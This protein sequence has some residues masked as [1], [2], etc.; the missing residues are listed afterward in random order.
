MGRDV[1]VSTKLCV[2]SMAYSDRNAKYMARNP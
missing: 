1:K 2:I